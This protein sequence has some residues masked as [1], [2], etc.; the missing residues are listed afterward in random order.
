[1]HMQGNVAAPDRGTGAPPA[2]PRRRSGRE[3][4]FNSPTVRARRRERIGEA[5]Q[6]RLQGL[7]YRRIAERMGINQRSAALWVREGLAFAVIEASAE[8]ERLMS[9]LRTEGLRPGLVDDI[10][11][12]QARL[13][14]LHGIAV[15]GEHA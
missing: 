9:V 15:G 1:M 3:K 12:A 11:N 8:L 6:L 4:A 14:Q 10:L 5:L 2:K 13:M 7:T